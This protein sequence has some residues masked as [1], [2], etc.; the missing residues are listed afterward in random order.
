MAAGTMFMDVSDDGDDPQTNIPGKAPWGSRQ[1]WRAIRVR[2]WLQLS[3]EAVHLILAAAVGVLGGL[4]NFLFFLLT[5]SLMFLF[6]HDSGNIA[7]VAQHLSP[8]ARLLTPAVGGLF[9]G[10]LLHWGAR[11]RKDKRRD[12]FVEAVVAGDGK[13]PF[14]INGVKGLSSL[15]SIS[16]GASI[17]R[18][19][20]ITQLTSTFASR[21][22]QLANW[23]PYR[24]RLMVAC[25]ASAGMAA[26]YNAPIAGTIFAAMIVLGNFSMS[27]FGPLVVAAVVATIVSRNFFGLEPVYQAPPVE[28]T[29]LTQLPWFL[30]LGLLAGALGTLFLRMLHYSRKWFLKLPLPV[31]GRLALGG[32]LV[33]AIAIHQPYVWGNGDLPATLILSGELGL[34]VLVTLFL[35][36]L[37]ATLCSVSSGAIGGVF[38]PT[39]FMGAALGGIFGLVL[40]EAGLALSMPL[41]VFILTGMGSVLAAT[42]HAPL[43]AMIMIFE[44]SLNYSIMPAL[45]LG[46]VVS[47]MIARRLYPHSIYTEPLAAKKDQDNDEAGQGAA[48]QQTVGDLMRDR[49]EPVRVNA[50]FHEVAKRFISSNYNFL[51]VVDAEERMVGVVALQDLKEHLNAGFELQAIIAYDIMRP[52]PVAVTPGQRLNA[53]M[54]ILLES[55][56]RN[57]P[58]IN[59]RKDW[60]LIGAISKAEALSILSDAIAKGQNTQE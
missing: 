38:T 39:L 37:V 49:V 12:N 59:N 26:A 42:L 60:Q 6:L 17:G 48:T 14:R 9:A 33:G 29:E 44:I 43:L 24:L 52:R 4:T 41:P 40:H 51:P 23:T 21:L 55:E 11:I 10:L 2:D 53:A 57:V 34:M 1:W 8:T 20:A 25:G 36:K 30:V 54:P 13:L 31:H 58:V 56:Q 50:L 18:E 47:S 16:T 3:E 5:K 19:G 46:C 28:F 27:L 22:G 7:D 15:I 32:L 45:M 35:A